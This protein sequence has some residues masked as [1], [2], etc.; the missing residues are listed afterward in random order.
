MFSEWATNGI[1]ENYRRGKHFPRMENVFPWTAERITSA[2]SEG[3]APK[4][5]NHPDRHFRNLLLVTTLATY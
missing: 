1:C 2:H 3:R 4:L 5:R